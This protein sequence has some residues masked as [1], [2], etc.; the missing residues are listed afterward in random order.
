MEWIGIKSLSNK[1]GL[2]PLPPADQFHMTLPSFGVISQYLLTWE[3]LNFA[4]SG[5]EIQ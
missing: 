5:S 2:P 3:P 4:K 1:D